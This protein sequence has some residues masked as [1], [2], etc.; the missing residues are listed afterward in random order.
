MSRTDPASEVSFWIDQICV[1]QQNMEERR[2]QVA[3]MDE[4]YKKGFLHNCMAWIRR[5]TIS[6]QSGGLL[7]VDPREALLVST[8][9]HPRVMLESAD[10]A[11]VRQLFYVLGK[12]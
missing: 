3:F 6:G 1:D 10:S 2:N 12:P 4:I 5:W 11:H 8:L 9:D 7:S